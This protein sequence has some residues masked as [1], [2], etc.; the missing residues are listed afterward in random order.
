MIAFFLDSNLC[1]AAIRRQD[2]ALAWLRRR[3]PQELAI[4]AIVAF[5]LHQGVA[6]SSRP[7]EEAERV[8]SFLAP[9]AVLPFADTAITEA[10]HVAA[11]LRRHGAAIGPYDVL[12][13]GHALALGAALATAANVREFRRVPRLRVADWSAA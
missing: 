5:E 11:H 13:A 9:L 4:S 6:L 10:V 2:A 7:V 8:R 1:I 12:I 3:S